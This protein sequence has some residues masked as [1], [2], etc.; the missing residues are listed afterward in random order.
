MLSC[1]QG[2]TMKISRKLPLAAVLMTLLAVAATSTGGVLVARQANIAQVDDKLTALVTV[3]KGG[4]EQ[5]FTRTGNDAKAISESKATI[6][7]L[8]FIGF[9][10]ELIDGDRTSILHQRYIDDNTNPAGQRHL[11][12]NPGIDDFDNSHAHYHGYFV[13]LIDGGGYDDVLLVDANGNVIYSV[14][15]DTDLGT[16]PVDGPLKETGIAAAF[17]Q[18]MNAGLQSP[19]SFVEIE[20][21]APY[22][23]SGA[24][25]VSRPVFKGE[26]RLGALILR[27]PSTRIAAVIN[28]REG[29]GENGETLLFNSRGFLVVD[30]PLTAGNDGF[31]VQI[32]SPLLSKA[33]DGHIDIGLLEGYRNLNA[34]SAVTRVDL[35]GQ[36]LIIATLVDEKEAFAGLTRMELVMLSLAAVI[37]LLCLGAAMWFSRT[38]SRP[39]DELAQGMRDLATG[40]TSIDL[41][42][43]RRDEIGGMARSVAVFRDAAIE[44]SRLEEQTESARRLT[45]QERADRKRLELEE[46]EKTRHAVEALAAGLERLA[47]GDVSSTIDV[48]FKDDLESLRENYNHAI[49]TL[50]R[51]LSD[52]SESTSSL[53]GHAKQVRSAADELSRRTEQQGTS[54]EETS[55]ALEEITFTVNTASDRAEDARRLVAETKESAEKSGE[56]VADAM[57]AMER[58]ETASGEI[59][60]IISIIDE[61]AFQTNLL[62]LN[63]GV[64]AARAGEAG[65][66]FAVVAQEVRDLAQRSADAAKDIKTLIS[67][68][69]GEIKS[70]VEL[71]TAAGTALSQIGE[72]V[73]RINEHVHAIAT[74]AREQATGIQGINTAVSQMEQTTQ[75]NAAMVEETNAISQMLA[76]ESD[77]LSSNVEQFKLAK[78]VDAGANFTS[79]AR[80]LVNQVRSAF[81]G[82]GAHEAA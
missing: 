18:A 75:Q 15:K 32:A 57:H 79:P 70:G 27:I 62:A 76:Q 25:F 8:E 65:K 60:A 63:A 10:F 48:A 56:V 44:K 72:A 5:F 24:A 74:G 1:F 3:N 39:I 53:Q 52:V 54:L 67:K 21:Y 43:E 73:M 69:D 55:A 64:E 66:G 46:Q 51:S 19:A 29:L 31:A 38:I 20:P 71:V 7:A 41:D 40:N 9:E 23:G 6:E 14:A 2:L 34:R 42:V 16:N 33:R 12:A 37:S 82:K 35:P 77:G 45:E 17:S 50:S 30:S 80:R 49:R 81:A 26:T 13:G 78:D 4:L 59:F 47:M 11:L 68:S 22:A 58:I 28:G 36:D 61:I